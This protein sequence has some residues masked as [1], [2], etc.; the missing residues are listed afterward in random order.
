MI[1]KTGMNLD[2]GMLEE[3]MRLCE[4]G[5]TV[6]VGR[7][8]FEPGMTEPK[9][10]VLPLHHRPNRLI[11]GYGQSVAGGI[12]HNPDK[13]RNDCELKI[14]CKGSAFFYEHQIFLHLF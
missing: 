5:N 6:R 12:E 14:G 2:T 1:L 4:R 10:V 9:P 8:G 7:L 11:C 13:L 3:G